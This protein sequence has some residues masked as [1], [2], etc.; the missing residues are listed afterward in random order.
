MDI[1]NAMS[2]DLVSAASSGGSFSS[3]NAG[4][5]SFTMTG[6]SLSGADRGN[7][8]IANS[9]SGT[10][11]HIDTKALTLT[12]GSISKTY[13]G[14]TGYS[15]TQADLDALSS[16]LLSGDRVTAA[17]LAFATK[18]V[19]RAGNGMVLSD[20]TVTLDSV[21]LNDGNGGANYSLTLQ[22]NQTSTITPKSLQAAGAVADKVY[23][24][25]RQAVL[26]DLSGSGVVAGD[27]VIFQ[28]SSALFDDKNVLR[29][30]N[31]NVL[32]RNVIVSGL[33]LTGSDAV[34]YSL[35]A[36]AFNTT[37]R[38]LP[39]QLSVRGTSVANKRQDGL[40]QATLTM[41]VLEG[42]VGVET[43]DVT[44]TAS[45][46]SASAGNGKPVSISYSLFNG[47][48]GGLASNYELADQVVLANI[49]GSSS[50]ANPAQSLVMPARAA[51]SS[52]VTAVS[53]SAS[54]GTVPQPAMESRD[55]CS[56]LTPD[57]CQCEASALA[58][59]D[60]CMVPYKL[61]HGARGL[62]LGRGASTD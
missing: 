49:L 62:V 7:Y 25:T 17:Q 19:S 14:Q 38:I 30:G 48:N 8:S 33:S 9:F 13:D 41:G 36:T 16:Q 40:T 44:A 50:G 57:D 56:S 35:S 54:L 59:V 22:G 23:D 46:A 61:T 5:H 21:T 47:L 53:A 20:K 52:K 42:L 24:G 58:G 11:G 28:A 2:G 43:L 1:T 6:L 12:A 18:N 60:I 37:A 31:G 29:D 32:S 10:T 45:F 27:A 26:G 51:A 3:K 34:N 15:V 39:K 55:E 4:T